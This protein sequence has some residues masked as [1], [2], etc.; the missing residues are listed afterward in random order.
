M[1][2]RKTYWHL[3]ELPRVPNDY[4]IA[5]SRLLYYPGRGFEVRT[6]LADWYA[7][8]QTGSALR[9]RDWDSFHDPR[10]T[11][12]TRYTE[13]QNSKEIFVDGLLRSVEAGAYDREL[14]AAWVEVL[15]RVLGPL[16]Y[17][18]HGLQMVAAY[19][20]SMAPGGR[21]VIAC[22]LQ[23][24]DEMRRIQR[25]A[26]RVC[27]LRRTYPAFGAHSADA[28]QQDARWQ[29]L[30]R[31]VEQL[32]VTYDWGEAFVALNFVVK[33]LVDALL[34][35]QLARVAERRADTLLAK[36]LFSLDEDC[37]W[38][39]EWSLALVRAANAESRDN[40]AFVQACVE[41]WRPS[42]EAAVQALVELLGVSPD[43]GA[44]VVAGVQQESL[45]LWRSAGVAGGVPA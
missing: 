22:L 33:P 44:Q 45:E 24:A 11:T 31:S 43:E 17:P 20:G 13:I 18:V 39:R 38:H 2:T 16:R 40:A 34:T 42:V 21:I 12:Y 3:Q 30:R 6:P 9:L 27:A 8:Y 14:A 25:L 5:T 26:Q 29:P 4:D 15:D 32:L 28:W 35:A 36:L 7:R 23:A 37:R 41:R 10:E 1:S 19:V